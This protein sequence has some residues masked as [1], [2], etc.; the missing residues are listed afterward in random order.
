[1]KKLLFI[2]SFLTA[3]NAFSQDVAEPVEM[4]SEHAT[5]DLVADRMGCIENEI[6][7]HFNERVYAFVNY[8]TV[9]NRPYTKEVIRRSSQFFPIIEQYLKKYGLPDELK[10]LSIVESG[11]NPQAISRVGAGGLWQF[12]PYTGNMYKLHQDWYIDER[13]DPYE[14]TDAAC[15][16]LSSLYTMFGDWELALAAYN[17]GPGN[18]RKAIRRSGYKKSFW[19]IYRYLPR[20]TRSYL[21]QF[22]A[23]VYAFNYAGELNLLPNDPAYLMEHDTLMVKGYVNLKSLSNELSF[24]YED[25]QALNPHLKRFGVKTDNQFYPVRLPSDKIE[26]ARIN[27][28]SLLLIA[29]SEGEKELEHLAQN[30]VGSTYGREKHVYRVKNGDVLGTIAQRYHVRVT[31][32]KKWNRLSSNTIRVGQSLNIW[33]YPGTQVKTAS[34]KATP[35]PQGNLNF[36]GKKT[37]IVQPG[38]TLWDISKKY[39]GLDIEKIKR[40]NNLE[41]DHIKPGQVL[42]IG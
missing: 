10:Y 14:A 41:S 26:L 4:F 25:I 21:P 9:K 18:V 24:C 31:D 8:F 27:R 3:L 28:D 36:D 22:V 1:M 12:M 38:D 40:L 20:E 16:Y 5:Y 15:K 6:P 19:E 17:S 30:S 11:L 42:I 37:Y 2:L 39:E 23:V 34:A 33:V 29:S 13:F 35:A 32:I 7:L